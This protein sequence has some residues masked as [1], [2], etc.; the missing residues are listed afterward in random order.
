MKNL[1]INIWD[2]L[3]DQLRYKVD[4][5]LRKRVNYD[6]VNVVR[7]QTWEELKNQNWFRVE[8]ET[9]NQ[10]VKILE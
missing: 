6:V 5:H 9:I 7:T 2:Y 10:I 4:D 1:K 8:M 3:N